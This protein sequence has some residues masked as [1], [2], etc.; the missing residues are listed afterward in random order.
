MWD[1]K[2]FRRTLL[3]GRLVPAN[4]VHQWII[5]TDVKDWKPSG[6]K[7]I[8][9]KGRDELSYF[10]HKQPG[11]IRRIVV[12]ERGTLRK[13]FELCT[14]LT[15]KYDWAAADATMFVLTDAEPRLGRLKCGLKPF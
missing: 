14:L 5:D 11:K 6:D 12:G 8:G 13:L 7:Y 4:D 1:V 15:R 2:S 9:S 3:G 10:D